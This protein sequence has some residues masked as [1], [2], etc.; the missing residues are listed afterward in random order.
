MVDRIVEKPV[1]VKDQV[2][3]IVEKGVPTPVIHEKAIYMTEERVIEVPVQK[4]VIVERLITN[5]KAVEVE[6][7]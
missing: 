5:E 3:I 6:V 4:E 1:M 7:I 2:S